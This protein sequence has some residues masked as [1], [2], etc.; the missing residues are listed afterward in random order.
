MVGK[1][2][3]S[4]LLIVLFKQGQVN[5]ASVKESSLDAKSLLEIMPLLDWLTVAVDS[6]ADCK[7]RSENA[8]RGSE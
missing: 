2:A 6:G 4:L 8:P 5:W 1:R 7:S 3:S